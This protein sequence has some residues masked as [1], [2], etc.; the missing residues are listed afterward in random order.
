[1]ETTAEPRGSPPTLVALFRGII[2][3]VVLAVLGVLI[4][5]LTSAD[6]G[7]LAPMAPVGLL[8]L[9]QA[10]GIF[11]QR[12]DP[13]AQRGV[14]GGAPVNGYDSA[15]RAGITTGGVAPPYVDDRARR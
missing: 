3:A 13:T 2:E 12:I 5:L 14:L 8:V 4:S 6:L 10:E 1:M 7:Q 9:R 15:S 11:D